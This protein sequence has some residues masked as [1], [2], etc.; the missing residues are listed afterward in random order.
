MRGSTRELFVRVIG[1]SFLADTHVALPRTIFFMRAEPRVL[2]GA[3]VR[4][5]CGLSAALVVSALVAFWTVAFSTPSASATSST[6]SSRAEVSVVSTSQ[7]GSVLVAGTKGLKGF[8]LYE[9]SGDADGKIRC[10]TTYATGY[11]LGPDS[12]MPLTCTGPESDLL[13][14]VKSDDWPAFTTKG[15]PLAGPGVNPALLGTVERRG[16]GDQVTYAGHPLYLFDPVSSPFEP[17]GEEYVETV[18]PL[19]P[20]HGYWF[21]VSSLNGD[22]A[23]GIATVEAGV[24]PDGKK[25]LAAE[26]DENVSPMAATVYAFSRDRPHRATCTGSCAVTWI[27]VLTSGAP[28]VTGGVSK[29][30]IGVLRRAGGL[31]QVTYDGAPLYWYSKERVFL[32]PEGSLKPSGT[33][34]NGERAKGPTGGTFSWVPLSSTTGA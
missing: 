30:A 32:T 16:I 33:A 27:P 22:P 26:V 12:K 8:P 31:E 6:A 13:N 20:W 28:H 11:D 14:G 3:R 29:A 10:G 7:Y 18:A 5:G 24:L 4:V 1:E 9:F 17:E 2:R 25:V 19:A 34:G 21:L 15:K 23:P